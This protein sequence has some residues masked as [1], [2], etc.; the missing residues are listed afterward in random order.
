MSTEKAIATERFQVGDRVRF[1]WGGTELEGTVVE[2]RGFLGVDGEQIVRVRAQF[3]LGLMR[4]AEVRASRLVKVPAD[5]LLIFENQ[6]YR[7]FL[8]SR[9]PAAH[10]PQ[11]AMRVQQKKENPVVLPDMAPKN[12]VDPAIVSGLTGQNKQMMACEIAIRLYEV[13]GQSWDADTREAAEMFIGKD[14]VAMLKRAH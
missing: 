7:I 2:D 4:D 9:S 3:D 12:E 6:D 14:N 11:P 10:F 13:H 1:P 8:V 5:G